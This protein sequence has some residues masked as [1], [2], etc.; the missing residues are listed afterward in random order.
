MIAKSKS[1]TKSPLPLCRRAAAVLLGT[2]SLAGCTSSLDMF[3]GSE[4]V[5]RTIATGTVPNALQH[6]GSALSDEATVRN[7][8]TSADL[9]KLG[10]A[11]VP[12][13][14]TA[15]GSAG[16]VSQIREARTEGQICRDFTTT[17]HSYEGIAMFSGQACL[18]GGGDWMLTAFDRQ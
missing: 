15:T 6:T 12:W 3:G 13:A 5:D 10:N 2:L 8:V 18:T 14:N 17:R 7:A 16:V 9:A 1:R 4:K 11:S